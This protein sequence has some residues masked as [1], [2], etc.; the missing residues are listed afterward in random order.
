MLP[1]HRERLNLQR[2]KRTLAKSLDLIDMGEAQRAARAL[3]QLLKAM[4]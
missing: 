2:E 4:E 1:L 3:A